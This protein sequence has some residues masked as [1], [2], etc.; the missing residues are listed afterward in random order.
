VSA[1]DVTAML[2]GKKTR[3]KKC[4]GKDG[5]P[6]EARFYLKEGKAAFEFEKVLGRG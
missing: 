1:A 6:F 3:L 4:A 5:K 2:A